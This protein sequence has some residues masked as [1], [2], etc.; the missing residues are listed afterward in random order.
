MTGGL[1]IVLDGNSFRYQPSPSVHSQIEYDDSQI[2]NAEVTERENESFVVFIPRKDWDKPFV[3]EAKEKE[4]ANFNRYGAYKVVPDEGQPQLTSGWI[5]TEKLYGDVVGCKAHLVVHGNQESY[6]VRSDSPTVTKQSLRL[7]FTLAAQFGWE[8]I[9]SDVTSAFLQ[10]DKLDR[11]IF[12]LPPADIKLQGTL[13]R[14]EKPMYGLDDAGLKWHNT[15]DKKLR[16]IGCKHLHTDLSVFYYIKE[17]RLRG[18]TAWHVDDMITT[19]DESFYTDVIK[20]LMESVK[21]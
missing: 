19:G 21:F 17:N 16:D 11:E 2:E 8:V 7:V 5:I 14:L 18:I 10:S 3:V 4:I 1:N 9:T 12:V 15:I 13:W 6:D 20:P